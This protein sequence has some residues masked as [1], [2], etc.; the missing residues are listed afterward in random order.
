MA[1]DMQSQ[2]KGFFRSRTGI[3]LLGFI[4]VAAFFLFMEHRAHILGALPYVILL[5]CPLFH[6]LGHGGHTRHGGEDTGNNRHTHSD[7][8]DAR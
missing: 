4:G 6:L 2:T 5:L 7:G 1:A 3:A 8:G